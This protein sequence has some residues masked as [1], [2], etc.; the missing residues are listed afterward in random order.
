MVVPFATEHLIVPYTLFIEQWLACTVT[1]VYCKKELLLPKLII[2]LIY[3][4]NHS[5]SCGDFY[6]HILSMKQ[7]SSSS[8]YPEIDSLPSCRLLAG[9]RIKDVDWA[10]NLIREQL[11]TPVTGLALWHPWAL[12]AWPV[13]FVTHSVHSWARSLVTIPPPSTCAASLGTVTTSEQEGSFHASS[14][15]SFAVPS[16]HRFLP[17]SS[18]EQPAAMENKNKNCTIWGLYRPRWTTLHR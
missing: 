4:G 8:F 17:P 13:N 6:E 12:L 10:S 5:Y 18:G 7:N 16:S 15:L 2:A 11:M 14:S 9:F 3:M 1:T